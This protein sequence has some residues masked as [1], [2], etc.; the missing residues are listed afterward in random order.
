MKARANQRI[1]LATAKSVFGPWTRRDHPVLM[2]RPGK[3]DSLM[4]TNP[5][6]CVKP[7]GSIL[8]IY[9][10]AGDQQ[11][12]LRMGVAYAR[13]FDGPYERLSDDMIFR[14]DET[15]DHIEDGYVWWAAEQNRYEIIMK[16]M[17]GGICG[18]RHA[19]IHG[20]SSDGVHWHISEP[21]LAY[22]RKI[23]WEDGSETV[24]GSLE[25]PQLLF[26]DGKPTHLFAATADGPGGF[27]RATTTW[28][29]V[30]PLKS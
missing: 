20:Y 10:S 28:N 22:S 13:H 7:D 19:G 3:W 6:P 29:M 1:G 18:E 15:G 25:R 4:T 17:K 24:Q 8:L 11:D 12:L 21:P 26:H 30:I 2:P 27:H 23:R 5:A 9:K 16:D 14:F